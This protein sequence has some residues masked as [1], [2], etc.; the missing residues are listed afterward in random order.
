MQMLFLSICFIEIKGVLINT[1]QPWLLNP[2]N[3]H[4]STGTDRILFEKKISHLQTPPPGTVL[5]R[6]KWVSR[7][8]NV[9]EKPSKIS[10][11]VT[12]P[13]LSG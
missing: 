3:L 13:G 7:M 11:L 4:L 2:L 6:N 8:L 1:V 10:Q 9:S 12:K 5:D